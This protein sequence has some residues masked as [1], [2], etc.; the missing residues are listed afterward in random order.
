MKA[1]GIGQ[2]ESGSEVALTSN[3]C[4]LTSLLLISLG[5][6]YLAPLNF[7]TAI[8]AA[9][10]VLAVILVIKVG[11]LL[12]MAGIFGALVG[13]VS[14][15]QGSTP[16]AAGTHAVIGFGVA[17]VTLVLVKLTRSLM[18]W[19]LITVAGVGVLYLWRLR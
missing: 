5:T 13:G 7:P 4:C 1:S 14:L 2:Q 19:L 10:L 6:D 18:L 9:L 8:V 16:T 15:G 17:V 11:K 3:A 12:L